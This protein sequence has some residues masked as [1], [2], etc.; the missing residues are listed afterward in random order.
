MANAA[1]N[2]KDFEIALKILKKAL[3]YAWYLKD[4]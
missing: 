3:Q 2:F 4:L 1:N